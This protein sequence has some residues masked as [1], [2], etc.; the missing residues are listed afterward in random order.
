MSDGV[1][2][3]WV[4]R[5]AY[6]LE[7]FLIAN[8]AFL[9]VDILLAHATNRFARPVEWLPV[10]FSTLAAA[11]LPWSS[12]TSWRHDS[13]HRGRAVTYV[14]GIAS[15][16]IGIAGLVFHLESQFLRE[17]TVKRL[18]YTAPFIAPLAYAGIGTLLILN[19]RFA[20]TREWAFGVMFGALGGF[21]GNFVLAL[22]DHAQNG[23]FN[24]LEWV[25]AAVAAL[26]T[27]GLTAAILVGASSRRFLSV[28]GI[29]LGL[30]C[31][32]GGVGFVFHILANWRGPSASWL[33]NFIHGAPSFAPL[34][35]VNISVLAGFAWIDLWIAAKD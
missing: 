4:R 15:V 8:L 3:F 10:G 35:F 5:R 34:L 27:G 12:L 22:C 11:I 30:Q 20:A 31:L 29:I 7:A 13:F 9:A 26:G 28:V 14:F 24:P 18:V 21:F 6:L 25:A 1:R 17:Q 32:T 23:F 33:E 16:A 2:N 19:R